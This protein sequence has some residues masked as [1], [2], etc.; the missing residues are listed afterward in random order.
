MFACSATQLNVKEFGNILES[1]GPYF[2]WRNPHADLHRPVAN[3]DYHSQANTIVHVGDF[4]KLAKKALTM[5]INAKLWTNREA[6]SDKVELWGNANINKSGINRLLLHCK[7]ADRETQT[8]G[9]VVVYVL[10]TL[11]IVFISSVW[12][13]VSPSHTNSKL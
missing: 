10:V 8:L 4:V 7:L 2:A 6:S 1:R 13:M 9:F 12:S 11:H 3:D 5:G